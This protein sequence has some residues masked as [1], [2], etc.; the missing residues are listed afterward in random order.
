M[1]QLGYSPIVQAICICL[2][3]Q[4]LGLCPELESWHRRQ[5]FAAWKLYMWIV[6]TLNVKLHWLSLPTQRTQSVTM[7]RPYTE[8]SSGPYAYP[9]ASTSVPSH[10]PPDRLP[11]HYEVYTDY[12]EDY[13][14]PSSREDELRRQLLNLKVQEIPRE[15]LEW[16][17]S[18]NH[19]PGCRYLFFIP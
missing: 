15:D 6:N 2:L 12:G 9:T 14:E 3:C 1:T 19:I 8:L 11:S 10:S 4:L 7:C 18:S 13:W 17:S 5:P 16:V